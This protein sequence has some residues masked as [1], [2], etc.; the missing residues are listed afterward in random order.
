[1]KKPG[2]ICIDD[3]YPESSDYDN[4]YVLYDPQNSA[5]YEQ[6]LEEANSRSSTSKIPVRTGLHSLSSSQTAAPKLSRSPAG[7]T[8]RN[9]V[10]RLWNGIQNAL[11]RARTRVPVLVTGNH[12]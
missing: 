2:Y 3:G 1:M 10:L 8:K 12:A 4:N 7:R 11:T 9:G 5:S 6:A